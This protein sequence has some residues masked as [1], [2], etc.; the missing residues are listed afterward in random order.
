M[1]KLKSGLCTPQSEGHS[2]SGFSVRS[3]S[4][5]EA[6]AAPSTS[7]QKDIQEG[8]QKS[9]QDDRL[10]ILQ[11]ENSDLVEEGGQLAWV[12]QCLL[13]PRAF[14]LSVSFTVSVAGLVDEG[15]LG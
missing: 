9:L 6:H 13:Q 8:A 4:I 3:H 10:T 7:V 11:M 1:W 2:A 15:D 5:G 12:L 14:S